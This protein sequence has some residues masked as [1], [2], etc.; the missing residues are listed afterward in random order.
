MKD[1]VSLPVLPDLAEID[2]SGTADVRRLIGE[3]HRHLY[4]PGADGTVDDYMDAV[5]KLFNGR[6]PAYQAMDTAYHDITHTLQATLC[7]VE[8]I[9]RRQENQASPA[10]AADDFRRALVAILFHDI[11]FLKEAGDLEGSGAKYT[12]LHEQRSCD[13]ARAFL[14]GRGWPDDDIRFVENLIGSTGPRV[15]VTQIAF[16]SPIER[17]MGQAVCTADYIGQISDPR[18]PD[19]LETLFGEFEESYRYQ[20]M[21]RAAWPF[22]SYEALLR[23][24]PAFWETFVRP[25]LNVECAGVWRHLEDPVTGDNPYMESVERNLAT[26][27]QR[28]AAL[29]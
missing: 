14:S 24:T 29:D 28:I 25:K 1:A 13:L 8:L 27:R 4:G 7:L 20:R 17:L 16:R 18:Y 26:I 15:D 6:D 22:A 19:R 5:E 2:F 21:P 9:H 23:A 10:I 3:R 11:G 12:H